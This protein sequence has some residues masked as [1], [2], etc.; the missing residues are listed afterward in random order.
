MDKKL[1]EFVEK[2]QWPYGLKLS[3][4]E[5]NGKMAKEFAQAVAAFTERRVLEELSKNNCTCGAYSI[6]QL[7]ID[8]RLAELGKK[9][10]DKG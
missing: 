3:Q 9:N 4:T 6:S 1:K 8:R 7:E 10:V 5:D 2:Y